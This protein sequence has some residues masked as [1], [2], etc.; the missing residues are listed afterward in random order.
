MTD[1]AANMYIASNVDQLLCCCREKIVLH[2]PPWTMLQILECYEKYVKFIIISD[3][4][5]VHEVFNCQQVLY[6]GDMF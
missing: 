1:I 3:S 5:R 2:K 6:I 4:C